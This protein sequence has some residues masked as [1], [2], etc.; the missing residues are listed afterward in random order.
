VNVRAIAQGSSELNVSLVVEQED[1]E[2][3][4]RA[5]HRTLFRPPG[6]SVQLYVA[7]VGRVG[8]ALLAQVEAQAPELHQAG[9]ELLL[10][11]L[12][13]STVATIDPSGIDLREWRATLEAGRYSGPE[14][15][16]A[17]LESD[18]PS[19]IFVDTTASAEVVG[20]YE[21][22][23]RDG[24]AVISA[25]KLAFAGSM[26][27]FETLRALG[28]RGM[29]I[30]YETTVGAGLPV[31][32]TIQDLVSTGD[33][34]QK[35]EGVLSGTLSFICD[36]LMAGVSFSS[37]LREADELGLTEPD[38][39]EDLGG[40]DVARKLVILGRI[41]GF[42]IEMADVDVKPLLPDEP[43]VSGSLEEFWDRLPDVDEGFV[44]RRRAAEASGTK[45]TYLASV[46]DGQATVQ[47]VALPSTHP[48]GGLSASENQVAVTSRRYSETRLVIQG[49]GAGPEVTA[50]GVFADVLRA[51]AESSWTDRI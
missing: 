51:L 46:E 11:G 18:H 48:C 21:S 39:R 7:G 38:P 14:M 13:R 29:G 45:L 17:L 33:T 19:R 2:R 22:L 49:P 47:M 31:L 15:V 43:W 3:A 5:I 1:E 20:S 9:V 40:R 10:V 26:E 27:Q 24:V 4:L 44:E 37:A 34:I 25:N 32:R 8:S 42:S 16:E 28:S 35:I 6:R 23:L 50:A 41:A 36:R 30:F 12:A